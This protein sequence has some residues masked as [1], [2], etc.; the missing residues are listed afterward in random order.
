MKLSISALEHPTV[1][2]PSGGQVIVLETGAVIK[3]ESEAMLQALHS[4]SVGGLKSHLEILAKRGSA[5]F[6]DTYYVGYGDKSIGDCGTVTVFVEGVSMLAAKAIQ[7]HPLYSG[8]EASTRYIDFSKQHFIDPTKTDRGRELLE[9]QRKFY[10]DAQEPTKLKLMSDHPRNEGEAEEVY[11]KAIRARAFD[12]TRSLLPA[13]ASTNLAW[14]VNLRQAAD[15]ILFLRHHPL[16]EVREIAHG[17]ETALKQANPN[18]FNHKRYDE[19]ERYQEAIASQY[20]F[21]DPS[22]PTEPIVDFSRIDR[23]ELERNRELLQRRPKKTELPKFLAHAGNL[24]VRYTLDFGSFRD[25]QRHRALNQRMPLLT[26]EL[27]FNT[28]YGA[29]LPTEV[30]ERLPEHLGRVGEGVRQLGVSRDAAQYFTP[31]GYNTSN[32]FTGDIPGAVYMVELRDKR[33]VHPTL[34]QV[35]HAIGDQIT[36]ELGIPLHRDPEPNRFDIRRGT[37]DIVAKN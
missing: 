31:M 15:R 4:R 21:H 29:N 22:S 2:L 13:G 11:K 6:I 27:G 23:E 1:D 3:P 12:I 14:H 24:T 26:T 8:Q 5:N 28:W 17:L 34:Q 19:T 20:L 30:A 37:Q 10:L 33:D 7:D 32:K 25:I 16:L 36:A 35:A 9:L 18:S